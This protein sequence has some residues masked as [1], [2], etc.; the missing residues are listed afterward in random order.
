[1]NK[2]QRTIFQM[3]YNY[4]LRKMA[5]G[6][7]TRICDKYWMCSHFSLDILLELSS[8][9]PKLE[10]VCFSVVFFERTQPSAVHMHDCPFLYPSA[11]CLDGCAHSWEEKRDFYSAAERRSHLPHSASWMSACAVLLARAMVWWRPP[12]LAQSPTVKVDRRNEM[13][14]RLLEVLKEHVTTSL[15]KDLRVILTVSVFDVSSGRVGAPLACC[16]IK[17]RDWCEGEQNDSKSTSD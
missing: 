14:S 9:Y 5:K 6:Y 7:N 15:M 17:L 4:K 13:W 3:T 16:E 11:S 8:L 12:E 10:L 2:V 1:M